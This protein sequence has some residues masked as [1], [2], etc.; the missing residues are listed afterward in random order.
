[1][2]VSLPPSNV[3]DAEKNFHKRYT[4]VAPIAVFNLHSKQLSKGEWN[5][6]KGKKNFT[7]AYKNLSF[8]YILLFLWLK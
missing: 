6:E 1:M 4:R 3:T 2:N 7:N 8:L 5:M